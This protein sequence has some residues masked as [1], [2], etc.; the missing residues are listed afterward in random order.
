VSRVLLSFTVAVV[1]GL[2]SLMLA[3]AWPGHDWIFGWIGGC[4]ATAINLARVVVP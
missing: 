3:Y 2:V 4:T 1:V